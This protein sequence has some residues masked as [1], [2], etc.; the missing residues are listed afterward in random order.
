MLGGDPAGADLAAG[1]LVGGEDELEASPGGP[2][3]GAGQR[4]GGHR[5]GG[6]LGLHVDRSPAPQK[7]VGELARPGIVGPLLGVGQDRV[8]VAEQA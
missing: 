3:A 7:A 5:L 2:P 4:D 6:D 8:D 1:L